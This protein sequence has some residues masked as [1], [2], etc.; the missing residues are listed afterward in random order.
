MFVRLIL[1]TFGLL[2]ALAARGQS[3]DPTRA[4][5]LE[6]GVMMS[7]PSGDL[8]WYG[9]GTLNPTLFPGYDVPLGSTYRQTNGDVWAKTGAGPMDWTLEGL[10]SAVVTQT[11]SFGKSGNATSNSYLNRSGNVPSNIAGESVVVSSGLIRVIACGQEDVDTYDIEVWQHEG[12]FTNPILKYTLTVTA[13]RGGY[14]NGLNISIDLGKQ[15]ALKTLDPVKNI[16][17]SIGIK[18]LSI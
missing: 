2:V 17:C 3:V 10:G 9:A 12:D 6:N 15:I 8:V 14:S 5:N 11:M 16:G 18:G 7:S 1:V 13:A 4:F